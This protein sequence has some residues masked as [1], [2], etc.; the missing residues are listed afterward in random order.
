MFSNGLK[1]ILTALNFSPILL[2]YQ[3]VNVI[4]KIVE[5]ND[6]NIKIG[7]CDFYPLGGFLICL[8]IYWIILFSAKKK[9]ATYTIHV[10]SIKNVD[11]NINPM[12]LSYF[13]PLAKP[14]QFKESLDTV[15]LSIIVI[16][17]ILIT[18]ISN[19]SFQYSP[20]LLKKDYI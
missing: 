8:M 1:Y 13:L 18:I 19:T 14:L 3:L 20:I 17:F 15:T 12:F 9:L 16:A 2:V 10:K 5:D 11:M 6:A 7:I 4:P